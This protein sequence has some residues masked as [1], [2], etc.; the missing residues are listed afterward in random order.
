LQDFEA[1]TPNLLARTVETVEGGG[2]VIML[3]SN[4]RSLTQLYTLT[5][6]VHARLRTDAHQTVT[7]DEELLCWTLYSKSW[8][9]CYFM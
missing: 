4:L 2:I 9:Q 7:G 8:Q 6:D 5:M 3:L 1:L